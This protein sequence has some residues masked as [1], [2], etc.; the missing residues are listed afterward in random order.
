MAM[1]DSLERRK[2]PKLLDLGERYYQNEKYCERGHP[3]VDL[4]LCSICV[5]QYVYQLILD[6]V[7][8]PNIVLLL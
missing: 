1:Y 7:V 4:S 5:R 6:T 8:L 2:V 3:I